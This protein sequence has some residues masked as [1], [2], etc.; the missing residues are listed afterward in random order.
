MRRSCDR[1]SSSW[2]YGPL[3]YPFADP[4][5]GAVV[6]I[7]EYGMDTLFAR[8]ACCLAIASKPMLFGPNEVANRCEFEAP[9]DDADQGLVKCGWG[10]EYGMLSKPIAPRWRFCC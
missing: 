5:A 8:G 1:P 6:G 7:D 10:A 2:L 9:D 3:E 4:I